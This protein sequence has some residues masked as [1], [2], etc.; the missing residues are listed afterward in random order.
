MKQHRI[1]F[2]HP[3]LGIGMF[4]YIYIRLYFYYIM[5]FYKIF[6]ILY[7]HVLILGGA[8][9]L[10][11]DAAVGLQNLGHT[12]TIYTSHRDVNHCFPE[13]KDGKK[14]IK[15]NKNIFICIFI[16]FY[17][18]KKKKKKYIYIYIISVYVYVYSFQKFC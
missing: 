3:D 6:Y 11:L 10:V 4:L 14:K 2:I 7:K 18:S 16:L 13:A 5:F 8:E 17:N 9:R 15:K 12:V 1:A